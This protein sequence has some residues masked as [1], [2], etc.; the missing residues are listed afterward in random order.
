M[1]KKIDTS[2]IVIENIIVHSIPRHRK[3]D[4]SIKPKYSEQESS[5]PDG[6]RVFFKDKIIQSL[7]SNKE[8]RVCYDTES[9]SPVSTYINQILNT[10]GAE[11]VKQSKLMTKYLFEIQGGQ[12]SSGILVVIFGKI[13]NQNTCIIIKLEKDEGAQLELDPKT[14]SFNIKDVKN[15]M[16]T[17]RTKIYKVGLFVDKSVFEIKY[18]G[19][20]ADLQIDPKTKKEVTTW[21]IEKFL[22]CVP[23]ADPRTTTKK[24]HD[25]TTTFIQSIEDPIKKA[26]YTQDL[27]SYLQKNTHRISAKEFADD[28]METS[29]KDLYNNY[30]KEKEFRMSEFPKDN[31]FIENKIKKLTMTFDNDIA[32]VGNKGTFDQNV[33]L[34]KQKDGTT[35]AEIISKVKS[36]R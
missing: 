34:E 14:N 33:K 21:F 20:T 17:R 4:F 8:L 18:D 7:Q 3:G 23:L 31:Y 35:K 28:Y 5:L 36:V 26:K 25:L 9:V 24:F 19:S 12:N 11:L 30:L 2:T 10:D 16:L 15:L 6:L 32:I 1:A 27:N 22:G 13:N 29:D